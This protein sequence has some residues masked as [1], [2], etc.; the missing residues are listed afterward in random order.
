MRR[1]VCVRARARVCLCVRACAHA[2]T[3][4]RVCARAPQN[5]PLAPTH[6][7]LK[8]LSDTHNREAV[9][10]SMPAMPCHARN[11]PLSTSSA[12]GY[13]KLYHASACLKRGEKQNLIIMPR[14]NQSLQHNA[15]ATQPR[16]TWHVTSSGQGGRVALCALFEQA[17]PLEHVSKQQRI[18]WVGE[19]KIRQARLSFLS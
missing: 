1:I 9:P 5:H 19:C 4:A 6:H 8:L 15:R 17:I 7:A 16:S 13:Q 12:S 18:K 10:M 14:K 11:L 3:C 2:C